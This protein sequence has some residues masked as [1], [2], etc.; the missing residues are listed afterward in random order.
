MTVNLD[1][2]VVN[3]KRIGF[4]VNSFIRRVEEDTTFY[5][6]FKNLRLLGFTAD[7]DIRVFGKKGD[8]KASLKSETRQTMNGRCRTMEVLQEKTTGDFYTSKG[9]Y[10]Y[11]TAELYANL[12]FTNGTVC[13][14]ENGDSPERSGG[15]L[16][17][18]KA[19]LKQ[20][21][22]NPGKPVKG[23]PIVGHKVAIFD[24]DVMRFYDFAI[25]SEDYLGIPCYVFAATAK[26]DLGR[27]DQGEIVINELTT[28]FNKD[29]FEIVGRRY[30]LSYKTWLFDFNVRMNVEMTKKNDLLI[31]ALVT[32]DGTWDV[33]F[34]KR[35]TAKFIAKF[36]LD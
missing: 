22:F 17:K 2:V 18:H 28:Y 9:K 21:I 10:N 31:P 19:Q 11:Y 29:N 12:F 34:K 14:D 26:K 33:P 16:E 4:D 20:L 3:A 30:S 5:R 25:T 35:E 13:V 32:Y 15:S 36:R 24:R 23:V 1:E 6:A 27:I 7:N 8:V